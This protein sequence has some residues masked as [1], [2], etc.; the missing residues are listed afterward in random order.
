[1]WIET[2]ARAH[3]GLSVNLVLQVGRAAPPLGVMVTVISY[4]VIYGELR[5]DLSAFDWR[6]LTTRGLWA[7]PCPG[8]LFSPSLR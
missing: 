1:M 2:R 5:T 4:I 3:A 8:L 6:P 7:P